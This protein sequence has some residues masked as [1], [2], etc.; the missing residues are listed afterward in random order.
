[1][2]PR[3]AAWRLHAHGRGDYAGGV[4]AAAR[5]AAVLGAC[6]LLACADAYAQAGYPV[7]PV[8]F[9]NPVAA[10]GN[11]EIVARAVA[12]QLS[13]ALGQQFIVESRPGASAIVGT[14]LV[15]AAAPDG[16][17]FL[18]VSNTFARV[19]A[20]VAAAGYDP[21]KDFLPV[22]LMADIPMVLSVNPALP[23]RTVKEL[24]ALAKQR[25]GELLY[26]SA[27]SGSTGH[28]AAEM[29]S[30]QAAIK[31][32]HVPYKGNAPAI[33]DLVGGQVMIM[34]DQIS[35][36]FPH[37]R[38]GKLRALGVTSRTR[39]PLFPDLPTIEEAGLRGFEDTTFNGLA[40]PAGTPQELRERLRQEM[41]KAVAVPE[42]RNRFLERGIELKASA[43]LDEFGAFLRKQVT[44]FAQL[45]KEAGIQ[46]N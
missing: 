29:F 46:S 5:S 4:D 45:A 28:V 40:A 35:T 18:A 7:K 33:I 31:M 1:M 19:P 25:P 39:S 13:K 16:Y 22:S 44:E 34:F 37:I 17:T 3:K 43:S 24:I 6:A 23:A 38:A 11:Q 42:A 36:S 2:A 27:G 14:R 20:I 10:G 32:L 12:E 21:L 8:R 26:A 15:K 30:R 9:I 41:V